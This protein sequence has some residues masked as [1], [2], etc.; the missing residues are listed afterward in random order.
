MA[1][2]AQDLRIAATIEDLIKRGAQFEDP[3]PMDPNEAEV[4]SLIILVSFSLF[5]DK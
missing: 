2:P 4:N 3:E 1:S 5:R